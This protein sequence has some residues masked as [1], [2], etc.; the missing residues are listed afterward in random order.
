MKR[1]FTLCIGWL[2]ATTCVYSQVKSNYEYSTSMPYGTLDIRTQ[3]SSSDYYYLQEN[4]TFSSRESAPGV[5]TNKYHDMTSWDSSPYAEGNLRRK[6]GAIDK[7][8]MNYR[9]LFPEG[10]AS[11]YAPGYPMMVHFHGA[12]ERANCYYDNCYHATPDYTLTVTKPG[13]YRARFSRKS[14]NPTEAQWNEWSPYV[15]ITQEGTTTPPPVVT[16]SITNPDAGQVFTAPANI[17]ITATASVTVGSIAKVEFYNGATKLA[18]D[19]SSP[20]S[21]PGLMSPQ[22]T[23]PWQQEHTTMPET[24]HLMV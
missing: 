16:V 24:L 4:R 18:E 19:N 14:S 17:S 23:M 12:V 10:Y 2:M 22:V 8:I 21:S 5:R 13:K 20:Y 1:L 9:L 3:I 11:T 15:T 7:F 6:T